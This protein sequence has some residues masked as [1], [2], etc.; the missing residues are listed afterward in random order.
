MKNIFLAILLVI[1]SSL[2][3]QRIRAF[4]GIAGYLDTDYKG[5][6]FGSAST[7]LEFKII[8]NFRPEVELGVMYGTPETFTEYTETGLVQNVFERTTTAINYSFCTKIYLGNPD[9]SNVDI[10]ILPK[11]TYSKIFGK[12]ES[13]TRNTNDL[14]KPIIEK[15]SANTWDD[16]FGI[17]I[18][19]S[20]NFSEKY[21]HSAD[22]IL[23]F[24]GVNLGTALKTINSDSTLNTKDTL[25]LGFLVYFGGKRK[26]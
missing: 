12:T 18:G 25:G 3:A 5:S 22:L 26:S 20:V 19:V 21:Y 2:Q 11:Y 24:N 9:D 1:T 23:Y 8:N 4:V 7:G 15:K 13:T 6:I 14:S 16:S 17:G 10:V